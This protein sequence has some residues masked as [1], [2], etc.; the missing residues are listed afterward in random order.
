MHRI[1][2]KRR[3][4]L[5]DPGLEKLVMATLLVSVNS[6]HNSMVYISR[7][8]SALKLSQPS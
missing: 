6:S 2:V 5:H 1:A 4:Q 3:L 7:E 8:D